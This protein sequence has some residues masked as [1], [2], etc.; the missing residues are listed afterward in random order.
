MDV[1]ELCKYNI[2]TYIM[3]KESKQVGTVYHWDIF[4]VRLT[5]LDCPAGK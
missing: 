3:G 4:I 2:Y 1:V 5:V